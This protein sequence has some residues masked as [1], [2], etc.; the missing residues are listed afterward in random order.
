LTDV[1]Y[2]LELGIH[3]I[4][5]RQWSASASPVVLW[6]I[7]VIDPLIHLKKVG[8]WCIRTKYHWLKLRRKTTTRNYL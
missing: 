4:A 1:T 8:K 3:A 2:I 6:I 7:N 5:Q